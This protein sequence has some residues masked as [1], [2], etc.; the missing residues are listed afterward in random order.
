M[1]FAAKTCKIAVFQAQGTISHY[2]MDSVVLKHT[3]HFKFLE[4]IMHN[5]VKVRQTYSQ[6]NQQ[7]WKQIEMIRRALYWVSKRVRL[8]LYKSLYLPHLEYAYCA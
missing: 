5:A 8:I 2:P 1:I 3:D 6:Q 7:Y 4:V